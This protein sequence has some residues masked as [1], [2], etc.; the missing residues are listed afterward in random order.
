MGDFR[1]LARP[2]REAYH[3]CKAGYPNAHKPIF[4]NNSLWSIWGKLVCYTNIKERLTTINRVFSHIPVTSVPIKYFSKT[5]Y[6]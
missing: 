1:E 3:F 2:K 6:Y 4:G 5:V